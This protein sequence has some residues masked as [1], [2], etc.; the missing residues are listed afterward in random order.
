MSKSFNSI[1]GVLA[2]MTI[3]ATPAF[4]DEIDRFA[5]KQLN[6]AQA[7]SIKANREYCG[8][9][10]YDAS[11]KLSATKIR[12]GRRD[13]CHPGQDPRGWEVVASFHTHGAYSLDADTEVPSLSDMREDFR[14][15]LDG[16]IATPGGRVWLN[17]VRRKKAVMIC[18]K[19]CVLADRNFK[20]CRGFLP[21]K[22]YTIGTLKQ[23]F[24]N[25]PGTC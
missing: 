25:D 22:Q 8:L 4:A 12:R 14:D 15:G 19:K 20:D 2:L 7:L 24:R 3:F 21:K 13:S 17:S 23:R 11:N 9:I 1:L 16:Y 18:G 5:I 6:K 10:G